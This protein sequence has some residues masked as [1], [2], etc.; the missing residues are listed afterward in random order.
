MLEL[1]LHKAPHL[2]LEAQYALPVCSL[3][4]QSVNLYTVKYFSVNIRKTLF[5]HLHRMHSAGFLSRPA[6]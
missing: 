2:A 5:P 1:F 4:L 3:P 6:L